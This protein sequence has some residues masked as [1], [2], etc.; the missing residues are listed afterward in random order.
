MG[1]ERCCQWCNGSSEQLGEHNEGRHTP[2]GAACPHKDNEYADG[3]DYED[4]VF[5]ECQ[6]HGYQQGYVFNAGGC[7]RTKKRLHGTC[8][9]RKDGEGSSCGEPSDVRCYGGHKR[10]F[11][12]VRQGTAESERG[13]REP[14]RLCENG[15]DREQSD[16]GV[17]CACRGKEGGRGEQRQKV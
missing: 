14:A 11:R 15:K 5:A 8:G 13:R 12:D 6:F 17:P 3:R 1:V 2:A 10:S 9:G 7:D 4:G 16:E